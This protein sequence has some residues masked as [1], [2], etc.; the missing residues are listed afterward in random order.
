MRDCLLETGSS[1]RSHTLAKQ[2]GGKKEEEE[3]DPDLSRIEPSQHHF[4]FLLK[5]GPASCLRRP[6]PAGYSPTIKVFHKM[7]QAIARFWEATEANTLHEI[8]R[9]L[10]IREDIHAFLQG[11]STKA[12]F[13]V[14][15]SLIS[16]LDPT[17]GSTGTYIATLK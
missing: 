12:S 16:R 3:A 9:L 14:F 7:E 10:H 8:E 15:H 6:C 11:N 4:C 13:H 17:L 2:E 5:P 1:D